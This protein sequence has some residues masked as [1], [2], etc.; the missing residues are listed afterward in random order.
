MLERFKK[1]GLKKLTN[2]FHHVKKTIMDPVGLNANRVFG[3]FYYFYY[4]AMHPC[5]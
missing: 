5:A 4:K 2:I 3:F 1:N